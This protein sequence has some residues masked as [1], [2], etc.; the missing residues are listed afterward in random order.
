[1]TPGHD[2]FWSFHPSISYCKVW[3]ISNC[4]YSSDRRLFWQIM[5]NFQYLPN[6]FVRTIFPPVQILAFN[7]T[8]VL[9]IAVIRNRQLLPYL[10]YS[11]GVCSSRSFSHCVGALLFTPIGSNEV[12]GNVV[13]RFDCVF[14]RLKATPA[15]NLSNI[16]TFANMTHNAIDCLFVQKIIEMV[17]SSLSLAFV[18]YIVSS[19]DWF[20]WRV[21]KL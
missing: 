18:D 4:V 21:Y 15:Y 9:G 13:K 6:I 10:L 17:F 12:F 14:S 20:V 16:I 3:R 2:S 7:R 8:F 19:V 1:M 5:A 11:G